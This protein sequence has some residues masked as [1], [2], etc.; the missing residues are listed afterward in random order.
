MPTYRPVI[1]P[2]IHSEITRRDA[3]GNE[4]R[5]REIIGEF[6]ASIRPIGLIRRC[7]T[8]FNH[9]ISPYWRGSLSKFRLTIE[10]C[11]FR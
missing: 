7:L 10:R 4:E 6:E 5:Q 11:G 9:E 3:Y 2:E 8:K 1:I